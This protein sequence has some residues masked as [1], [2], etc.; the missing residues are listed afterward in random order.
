MRCSAYKICW[1]NYGHEL[2]FA[3]IFI[4]IPDERVYQVKCAG[5]NVVPINF[6]RILQSQHHISIV[7]YHREH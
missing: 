1:F 5:Y 4:L 6:G 7:G 2:S 3:L